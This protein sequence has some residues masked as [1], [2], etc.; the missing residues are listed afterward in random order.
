MKREY[1]SLDIV[2]PLHLSILST[3]FE[4]EKGMTASQ[5]H[6][7]LEK[8]H[9]YKKPLNTLLYRLKFLHTHGIINKDKEK[10]SVYSLINEKVHFPN[11]SV[12]YLAKAGKDLFH[13]IIIKCEYAEGCKHLKEIKHCAPK[14][15]MDRVLAKYFGQDNAP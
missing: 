9:G 3:L 14:C 1:R 13:P 4:S 8:L 11:H 12:I 2:D 15:D 6:V 5:I 7:I 10:E